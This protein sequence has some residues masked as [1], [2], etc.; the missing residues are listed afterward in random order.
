MDNLPKKEF[1]CKGDQR[2]QEKDGKIKLAILIL[3]GFTC[4]VP[5]CVSNFLTLVIFVDAKNSYMKSHMRLK[6][7]NVS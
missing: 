1:R 7:L 2:T 6:E 4:F 3:G 5:S